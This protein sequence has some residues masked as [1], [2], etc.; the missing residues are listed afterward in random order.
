M[1]AS[2]GARCSS[3]PLNLTAIV[4]AGVLTLFIQRL[5]YVRRR[6]AHLQDG[7]REKAGLPLGRSRRGAASQ[8]APVVE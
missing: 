5:V 4:L 2:G 1:G 7:A 6:R 3:S 8:E